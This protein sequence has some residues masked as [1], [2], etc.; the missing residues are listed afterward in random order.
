MQPLTGWRRVASAIWRAP[1][2]PQIYG[3]L[4][5]EASA[6]VAYVE[7]A[8]AAGHHVT[9]TH[10][11][12]R[13][14]AHALSAVPDLNV[15]IVGSSAIPRKSIDIF[16]I[17]A[18]SGGHDLSGVK[19]RNADDKSAAAIADELGARARRLRDGRDPE[20]A[21]TKRVMDRLPRP[22]L[23]LATRATKLVTE[24]L[25]LDVPPLGLHASPFGSA[26]VSS[27]GMFGLPHGFAPLAWIY[28]VPLIVLVGELAERPLVVDHEVVARP[29]LPLCATIDHRYVDG[30]HVSKALAAFREY[31]AAPERFEPPLSAHA[32]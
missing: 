18:V 17:T 5:A 2:D 20:F 29:V 15:R 22:L 10:L 27:V 11:V 26:M 24:T 4:D 21:R 8:R 9:P 30:W 13:A 31:L 28:D 7:K 19:V 6:V 12:G 3:T 16:F 14:V 32:A 1:N 23:K 25:A